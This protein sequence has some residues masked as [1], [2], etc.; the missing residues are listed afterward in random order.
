MDFLFVLIVGLL[1]TSGAYLMMSG[2]LVRFLYGLALFS[3]AANLAIFVSGGLSYGAPALIAE[4]EKAPLEPVANA[5]PQALVLTAIVI[6]FGLTVFAL[7]LA[8][9]AFA[10][11]GTALM[12]DM[13]SAEP[14]AED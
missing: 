11:E 5:L 7:A 6:G 3:N 1:V 4:G 12:D 9:R 8:K 10:S 13:R 14:R 2:H